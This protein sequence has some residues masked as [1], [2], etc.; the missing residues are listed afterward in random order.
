[1]EEKETEN[2]EKLFQTIVAVFIEAF[3][4]FFL[5]S[6]QIWGGEKVRKDMKLSKKKK[7]KLY[8]GAEILFCIESFRNSEGNNPCQMSQS[9]IYFHPQ[10]LIMMS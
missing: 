6:R 4:L 7:M 1:M 3:S 5:Q 8:G 10:S 9:N 2:K